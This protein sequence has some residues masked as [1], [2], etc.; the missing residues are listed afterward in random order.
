MAFGGWNG[1]LSFS[2]SIV[3]ERRTI[4]I[5]SC[6]LRHIY[7]STCREIISK[8]RESAIVVCK[9]PRKNTATLAFVNCNCDKVVDHASQRSRALHAQSCRFWWLSVVG[10]ESCR[11]SK[12]LL[13]KGELSAFLP[14]S[15]D[16]HESTCKDIISKEIMIDKKPR[17]FATVVC[18]SPRKNTATLACV[19]A[20]MI[21]IVHASR[22]SRALRTQSCRFLMAFGSWHGKLPFFKSIVAE[23]RTICIS[24]C[25]LRY[26]AISCPQHACMRHALHAHAESNSQKLGLEGQLANTK[27]LENSGCILML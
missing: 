4:C 6:Q 14:V 11:F 20:I 8:S 26:H 23:R 22:R 12:A 2:K 27:S 9:S 5:S 13:R 17:E 15:S 25:Q 1:K 7:E 16:I 3:A 10:T 19:I 24:S 21:Y 18:K